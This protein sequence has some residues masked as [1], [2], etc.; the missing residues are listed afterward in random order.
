LVYKN[1]L[2]QLFLTENS[3]SPVSLKKEN[4]RGKDWSLKK[5][6]TVFYLSK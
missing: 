6:F 5:N 4:V 1:Q 2:Q 3:P